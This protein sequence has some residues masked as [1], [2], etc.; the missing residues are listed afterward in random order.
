ML[1]TAGMIDAK[2]GGAPVEITLASLTPR[3]TIYAMIDRQNLP[4]LYRTF[5]FA[6]PDAHSPKRYLTTVP[7]QALFLLNNGQM[8]ELA[9]RTAIGCDPNVRATP[10]RRWQRRCSLTSCLG[11]RPSERSKGPRDFC[12][13][14][15]MIRNRIWIPA[16]SGRTGQQRST[17]RIA[18]TISSPSPFSR[19]DN[20]RR[21]KP[22]RRTRHL[23]TR[24]STRK[25]DT[26]RAT[27]AARRAKIHR[28]ISWAE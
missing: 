24:F 7:Q 12:N 18:P 3:R 17:K 22:S 4:S 6:S 25:M 27:E 1:Y 20:G 19:M 14:R 11:A 13:S 28:S 21:P 15:F 26:H 23:V 9:R 16:R 8:F 2:H 10:P 5:D